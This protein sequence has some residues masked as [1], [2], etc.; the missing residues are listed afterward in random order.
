MFLPGT[1]QGKLLQVKQNNFYWEYYP[2]D[3][4]L[5]ITHNRDVGETMRTEWTLLLAAFQHTTPRESGVHWTY[6]CALAECLSRTGRL[7]RRMAQHQWRNDDDEYGD[8]IYMEVLY[9]AR[10]ACCVL[11]ALGSINDVRPL[12][13]VGDRVSALFGSSE[14]RDS[15][16]AQALD[17]TRQL[18]E[19]VIER[20]RTNS[21]G[22]TVKWHACR[23]AR[24]AP[25]WRS[26]Y[27]AAEVLGGHELWL[28]C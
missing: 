8:L 21:A 1:E 3:S 19:R 17:T 10:T 15:N 6:T 16:Q 5:P 7:L 24:Q 4:G 20:H 26:A 28:Q 11:T 13:D 23:S 18:G 14:Q 12:I 25:S 9:L 27:R 22:R 2:R